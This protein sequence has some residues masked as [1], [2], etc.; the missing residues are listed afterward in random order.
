[1]PQRPA[2]N[3]HTLRQQV[4]QRL[5]DGILQGEL[6][7]GTRLVASQL[8]EQW[9]ISRTPISEALLLLEQEGLVSRLPTGICE[10]VGL[11]KVAIE[12]LYLTRAALEGLCALRAAQRITDEGI[13]ELQSIMQQLNKATRAGD[14]DTVDMLG[15]RFHERLVA[16]SGL[17]Y[18]P[19]L[20]RSIE[21]M[22][23]RY[24]ARTIASPGRPWEAFREHERI[25]A[26]LQERNAEAARAA[27]QEHI[28]NAYHKAIRD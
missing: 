15:K 24:R 20:L 12:E 2:F 16:F 5:R 3:L 7:R 25:L 11:S 23:D 8:A 19:N 22:I 14:L 10:V 6:P 1:M 9:G 4:Y 27:M 17:T 18:I 21:G 26:A 13:A 28:L